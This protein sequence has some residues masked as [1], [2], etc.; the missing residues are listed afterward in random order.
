MDDILP[1]YP[2]MWNPHTSP[3]ARGYLW[4]FSSPRIPRCTP[5]NTVRVHVRERGTPFRMSLESISWGLS[6]FGVGGVWGSKCLDLWKPK[7][8]KTPT[9]RFKV[10]SS[11]M[12][13]D[14]ER[15]KNLE[16]QFYLCFWRSTAS[17]NKAELPIKTR[18]FFG[19]QVYICIYI[20]IYT[21][22]QYI[23]FFSLCLP[24]H[25]SPKNNE[26]KKYP[27]F[28]STEMPTSSP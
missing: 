26:T 23:S 25:S 7:N 4:V 13:K 1:T 20:Y 3:I 2:V 6:H 15:W 18:V 5:I 28:L 19:F 10:F 22:I 8:D 27:P 21:Y 12:G 14:L 24:H 16:P 11:L 9:L 17:Q